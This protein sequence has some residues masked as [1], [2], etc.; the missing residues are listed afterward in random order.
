MN[1]GKEVSAAYD[2]FV[3]GSYQRQG[4]CLVRGR[5]TEAFDIE[6]RRYLDFFP[7]WAVSGLGHC[8]PAVVEAIRKQAGQAIHFA[9]N[10]YH[11]GQA[12]LARKI[13]E[14]SFPGRCFF[15]N[16]GAEANEAAIKLARLAG[17]DR[18][19]YQVISFLNSFHGRTLATL[20][21][22]GQKK[23]QK[24]F[25]PLP[26]G[27]PKAVFNDLESV[28]KA[29]NSKTAAIFVEPIQGEG[30]VKP[31]RGSFLRG[32][33]ELCDRH[34]IL[35]VFDE[36]QTGIGRTGHYF[37]FQDYG[38]TPD[39]MTLAKSLGGGVPVGVMVARPQY[40]D[41]MGPGTHASTF[42]GGPLA[43]AAS[44][45]VFEAIEK[46]GLLENA[47]VQ[48]DC[49]RRM[50]NGISPLVREVRGRGLMIG[51]E[52][53]VPGAPIVEK[54]CRSGLLINCTQGSVLRFMP[55]L[56]V[57][58]SEIEEAIAILEKCF[59]SRKKT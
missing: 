19:R 34:G 6:G 36:V 12:R 8:H 32:L 30:G 41:L 21:L 14:K 27:F 26:A 4:V 7:G 45:A 37:A 47:L 5:A 25:A 16:S 22:T 20:T 58:R 9:N 28:R 42:G 55:P 53:K 40:A 38:V 13:I 52:L 2:Q 10:F 1:T 50:L 49:L 46:E 56:T 23:L 48:G 35:L 17:R 24:G 39:I 44:L 15:C 59:D 31:A 29:V 43:C 51:V 33:R 3:V 11:P 57:S 18:G 54:A